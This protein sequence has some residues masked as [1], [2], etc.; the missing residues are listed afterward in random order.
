MNC[1]LENVR[2]AWKRQAT[3]QEFFSKTVDVGSE[4]QAHGPGQVIDT[5]F[6]QITEHWAMPIGYHI[7]EVETV[8]LVEH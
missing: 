8:H 7:G 5:A 3:G 4:L 6:N 2:M 1:A